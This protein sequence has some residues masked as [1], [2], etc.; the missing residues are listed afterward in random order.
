[1]AAREFMQ[2]KPLRFRY[3]RYAIDG[4]VTRQRHEVRTAQ[5]ASCFDNDLLCGKWDIYVGQ[6]P[7][8]I[9]LYLSLDSLFGILQ[10]VCAICPSL[11]QTVHALC[12]VFSFFFFFG[13]LVVDRLWLLILCNALR[14]QAW[15][16]IARHHPLPRTPP[17]LSSLLPVPTYIDS[18][19]NFVLQVRDLVEKCTCPS[20]FP[21]VRVSEGKYRI[22]DTKVLIFVRV[23][24]ISSMTGLVSADMNIFH[25]H[26]PYPFSP[27]DPALACHG[28]RWRRLG[29]TLTLFG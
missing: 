22:G 9:D 1:M 29:H 15:G 10:G 14:G 19:V 21:M 24:M 23:S 18:K 25:I 6:I 7:L 8:S 2:W 13:I 5:C 16:C 20:Q 12:T 3:I 26:I 28:A 11:G 4:R 17:V 27:T